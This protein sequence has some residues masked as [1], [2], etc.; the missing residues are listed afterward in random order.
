MLLH[1]KRTPPTTMAASALA[2]AALVAVAEAAGG[3]AEGRG[4]FEKVRVAVPSP[5]ELSTPRATSAAAT[6]THVPLAAA[7]SPPGQLLPLRLPLL[8]PLLPLLLPLL[9]A[10]VL[11]GLPAA[12]LAAAAG[13]MAGAMAGT[14]SSS[15][16]LALA[17]VVWPTGPAG[18]SAMGNAAPENA[19]ACACSARACNNRERERIQR[20]NKKEC[21]SRYVPQLC[22]AAYTQLCFQNKRQKSHIHAH[23]RRTRAR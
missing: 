14:M 19:S 11:L 6:V 5:D 17:L 15:N 9:A 21:R 12:S 10:S 13:A 1:A 18:R 2:A 20:N 4:W 7:P 8:P 23:F 3:E 16:E 22:A